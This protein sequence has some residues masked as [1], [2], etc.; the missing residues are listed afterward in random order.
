MKTN[1]QRKACARWFNLALLTLILSLTAFAPVVAGQ[2]S[3]V[4][5]TYLEAAVLWQQ[6]SGE[7]RALSYQTFTLARM[8]LDRDLRMNRR[9]KMKRAVIVDVDE[10]VL[11]NSAFQAWMIKNHRPYEAQSWTEW[12]NRAVATAVPGAVEFLRYA[13]SR[14]VRVFYITNRKLTEKEGTA[15]NLKK[16]GFPEVNEQTLLVSTDPKSSSKEPRRLSISSRYRVVLLMGDDLND[17][18]EVFETSK[19]VSTR[20]DAVVRNKAQFGARFIVLPN[21]MYGH[22][23]DAIYGEGRL[24][25]GE[26]AEKRLKALKE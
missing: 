4:D 7:R 25:A 18:A 13:N 5:N 10:T 19:T 1:L 21:P 9:S 2:Q 6:S 20:D 24:T 3:Q 8:L 26:K 11:D 17:F 16:V 22:W 23:E 15:T 12:C 14:G